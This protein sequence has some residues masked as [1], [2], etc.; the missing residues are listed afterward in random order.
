M[1]KLKTLLYKTLKLKCFRA[2]KLEEAFTHSSFDG[3][4]NNRKLAFLGD[5]ILDLAVSLHLV[6]TYPPLEVGEM[7]KK[8]A[9]IVNAN[10][11]S[12]KAKELKL[13]KFIKLGNCEKNRDKKLSKTI[14]SETV[15]ALIASIYL[16]CGLNE[17]MKFI[18]KN[19]IPETIEID[20]W[21]AKGK[22]QELTLSRGIGLPQY[23]ICKD[24]KTDSN[25]FQ[26]NVK[27]NGKIVCKGNG[28]SKKEA[29]EMA[30][31]KALNILST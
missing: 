5:A 30:A 27:V 11:L 3:T 21:N 8:R 28:K 24:N 31:R 17:T 6:R 9:S 29:E 18:N 15:E 10:Y 7:T 25:H 14:L 23:S 16:S 2:E 22:L 13:G 4:N 1:H 12:N 19:I 20:D 26:I